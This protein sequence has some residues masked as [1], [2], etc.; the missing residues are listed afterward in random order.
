[1][2]ENPKFF[3]EEDLPDTS[4]P[5]ENDTFFTS[6][7]EAGI[8]KEVESIGEMNET[9]VELEASMK[10]KESKVLLLEYGPYKDDY[11]VHITP[12]HSARNLDTDERVKRAFV[13]LC[14]HLNRYVPKT[15]QVELFP[16]NPQWKM[17][18]ISAVI[19]GGPSTWN[20]NIPLFEEEGIPALFQAVEKVIL[21]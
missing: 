21:S 7:K 20:F 18:V 8:L 4:S 13:E 9:R 1:M 17:K 19:K 16:P 5:Q 3:F 6:L 11:A 10:K 15:T 12:T 2:S 14:Q